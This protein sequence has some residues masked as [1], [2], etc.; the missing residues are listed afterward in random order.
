GH[1]ARPTASPALRPVPNPPAS[2]PPNPAA[3]ATTA[4][5]AENTVEA[6]VETTASGLPR[7][8]SRSLK[9]GTG[10]HAATLP[11]APPAAGAA[12]VADHERLLADLGAFAEGERA[13]R[14]EQRGA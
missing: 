9:S 10:P 13:A 2:P 6:T 7:R 12:Q 4:A 14:D 3:T 8:V 5:T 1:S 11:P